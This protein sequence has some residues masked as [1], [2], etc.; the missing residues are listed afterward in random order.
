M[1]RILY[2]LLAIVLLSACISRPDNVLDEDQMTDVLIDVHMAEGLL[3]MQREEMRNGERL[4]DE[5][6]QEIIAAVLLRHGVM[7]ADYDSSLVWYSKNLKQLIRV[8]DRVQDS[9]DARHD[10]WLAQ[11]SGIREFGVSLQG[12]S[13]QLWTLTDYLL[14]QGETPQNSR[15]WTIESDSNYQAGDTLLW[16]LDVHQLEHRQLIATLAVTMARGDSIWQSAS[17]V[18]ARADRPYVLTA[19]GD[20]SANIRRTVLSV[21]LLPLQSSDT[22]VN[23]HPLLIDDISLM[24]YHKR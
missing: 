1:R 6:Q 14:L 5:Y 18:V 19:V 12:D 11:A 23:R 13:V 8:Y 24:R 7:K 2:I 3:D 22:A 4:T 21:Y 17:T 16:Q 9:L 15:V 10:W 20:S